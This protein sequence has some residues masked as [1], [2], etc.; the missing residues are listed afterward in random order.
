MAA[1]ARQPQRPRRTA[2][3]PPH[4]TTADLARRPLVLRTK[5]QPTHELFD[6]RELAQVAADLAQD[7]QRR[8]RVDALDHRQVHARHPVERPAHVEPRLIRRTATLA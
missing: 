4:P 5:T 7:Y 8:R 3:A 6:S 1:L 2:G